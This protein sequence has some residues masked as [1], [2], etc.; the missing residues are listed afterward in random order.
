MPS[1]FARYR[2]PTK[3]NILKEQLSERLKRT[4]NATKKVSHGTQEYVFNRTVDKAEIEL[5]LYRQRYPDNW[6]RELKTLSRVR[7]Q[8]GMFVTD[9][10]NDIDK[11]FKVKEALVYGVA[12]Q[13]FSPQNPTTQQLAYCSTRMGVFK[14]PRVIIE[15]DDLDN[16]VKSDVQGWSNMFYIPWDD[17]K[18]A[19]GVLEEFGGKYRNTSVA[20]A[21]PGGD[22]WHA[23]HTVSV[24]NLQEWLEEDFDTLVGANKGGFL[25]AEFGGTVLYKKDQIAKRAKMQKEIEE[26]KSQK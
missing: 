23:G 2:P 9:E 26:L 7:L 21:A 16:I 3:V 14:M 6:K 20:I 22:D 25:K 8:P 18:S 24:F 1:S 4:V 10:E 19:K 11:D 17:G 12:E 13:V 15:K 5:S